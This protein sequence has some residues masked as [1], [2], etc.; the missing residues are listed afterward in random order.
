MLT[1]T[2]EGC[3]GRILPIGP[4]DGKPRRMNAR[5][6]HEY[7]DIVALAHQYRAPVKE[8]RPVK[9]FLRTCFFLVIP[10]AAVALASS[11]RAADPA[12]AKRAF[13]PPA[14]ATAFTVTLSADPLPQPLPYEGS[15]RVGD[16]TPIK[17]TAT[18][19]QALPQ[20]LYAFIATLPLSGQTFVV[21]NLGPANHA[22]WIP[23]KGGDYNF[24]VYVKRGSVWGSGTLNAF[25]VK[26]SIASTPQLS[27]SPPVKALPG[28]F[29]IRAI[30]PGF[31]T[32]SASIPPAPP[33]LSSNKVWF[34]YTQ[35]FVPPPPVPI[36]QG[37]ISTTGNHPAPSSPAL[38]PG[39]YTVRAYAQTFIHSVLVAEGFA[40]P[41]PFSPDFY[42]ST[43]YIVLLPQGPCPAP[44]PTADPTQLFG[45][46]I[47]ITTQNGLNLPVATPQG[48]ADCPIA[49][50]NIND[51][52]NNPDVRVRMINV[53]CTNCHVALM[54]GQPGRSWLCN[55]LPF[56]FPHVHYPDQPTEDTLFKLLTNWWTRGCPD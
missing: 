50:Y 54:A 11:A 24:T 17:L 44:T 26:P 7:G 18:S 43:Y 41:A 21:R 33:A 25:H 37:P 36:W 23:P 40:T 38:T 45:W 12:H 14:Q 48:S 9:T 34:S 19:T 10:I 52:A 13:S 3:T 16:G 42:L 5:A 20:A 30:V 53:S 39:A 28:A 2:F 15:P 27:A 35:Q 31:S 46:V 49:G 1:R 4:A 22:S 47:P 6:C 51:I 32:A 8:D 55:V 29:T 56:G